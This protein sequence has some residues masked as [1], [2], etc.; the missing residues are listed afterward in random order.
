MKNT[1]TNP[2]HIRYY[3]FASD[4]YGIDADGYAESSALIDY[5][6]HPWYVRWDGDILIARQGYTLVRTDYGDWYAI[7]NQDI[8]T[9]VWE[10]DRLQGGFGKN[11]PTGGVAATYGYDI[12]QEIDDEHVLL[13]QGGW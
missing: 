6:R 2:V 11:C 7:R 3:A 8:Y 12:E 5:D 9:V 10:D 13:Q 4:P 1:L